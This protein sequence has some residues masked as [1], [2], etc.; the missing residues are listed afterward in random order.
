MGINTKSFDN[1]SDMITFSRSSGGYGFTKVGYGS[2]LVTNGDFATDLTGWTNS[3]WTW[4]SGSAAT[5]GVFGTL[6]QAVGARTAP[7]QISIEYVKTSGRVQCQLIDSTGANA[8][9]ALGGATDISTLGESPLSLIIPAGYDTIRFTTTDATASWT[10]DNVSV[11]EVTYN[12]SAADAT[13]QLTYHPNDVPRIE[14]NTDGTAKGLLVEEARTNISSNSLLFAPYQGI[15]AVASTETA[16]DGSTNATLVTASGNG[17]HRVKA[18]STTILTSTGVAYSISTFVKNVDA[19]YVQ[20]LNGGDGAYF[21]TFDLVNETVGST[22]NR[23]TG[24]ITKY[25]DGWYRLSAVFDGTGLIAN[26]GTYIYIAPSASATYSQGANNPGA[27]MHL[28]G[29]QTE[30]GSFPTSYIKTTGAAATRSA[31]AASIGVGEFGYN[32]SEGSLVAQYEI[33]GSV[34]NAWVVVATVVGGSTYY[35]LALG[36]SGFKVRWQ[37]GISGVNQWTLD[38]ST[39]TG[40]TSYKQAGTYTEN[41]FT[42]VDDGGTVLTDTSGLVPENITRFDIGNQFGAYLNGHIKSI[43]YYPRRL[44]DAQIQR[45]TQPISTP[46]LSLTFDGQATSFTEDSIHG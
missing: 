14:Y 22:G 6:T 12:S 18:G 2:E 38:T 5:T 1:A 35:A 7:K 24:T 33:L 4:S 17:P 41:N 31:D 11:K 27:Q 37:G 29:F 20:I 46:T 8:T 40:R 21:A 30:A 13:L 19:N 26:N 9:V 16:P 34:G 10:I 45:L 15:G 32:Q 36:N 42:A 3:N 25:P 23:T 43:K 39:T 44:T 28:W